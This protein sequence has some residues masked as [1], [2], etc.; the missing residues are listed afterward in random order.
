MSSISVSSTQMTG[1][2]DQEFTNKDLC[3]TVFPVSANV[4]EDFSMKLEP[5]VAK[6][7]MEAMSAGGHLHDW[8]VRRIWLRTKFV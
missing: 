1:P 6:A 5:G 3:Y 4:A 7:S 2:F 8:T